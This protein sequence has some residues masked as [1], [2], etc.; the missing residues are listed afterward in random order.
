MTFL[1]KFLLRR[2]RIENIFVELEKKWFW[3]DIPCVH[4]SL[5]NRYPVSF[6]EAKRYRRRQE[7]RDAFATLQRCTRERAARAI[8]WRCNDCTATAR[9]AS[10]FIMHV[11]P[12]ISRWYT[13]K[14]RDYTHTHTRTTRTL[15]LVSGRLYFPTTRFV[16]I[17][18][19]TYMTIHSCKRKREDW[20]KESSQS[21]YIWNIWIFIL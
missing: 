17:R 15:S 12:H 1:M 2:N 13:L 14:R 19:R 21:V 20:L 16:I 8:T 3:S 7:K 5:L 11:H 18:K 6:H 4:Q 9:C 10:I